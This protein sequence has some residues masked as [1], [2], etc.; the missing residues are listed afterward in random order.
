M[1]FKL[2]NGVQSFLDGSDF[3][4]NQ[5]NPCAVYA[6]ATIAS[7]ILLYNECWLFVCIVLLVVGVDGWTHT[8]TQHTPIDLK[9][10]DIFV[11]FDCFY[12]SISLCLSLACVAAAVG[13]P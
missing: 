4:P 2:C 9:F 11:K 6:Y 7:A 8:H 3:C 10:I 12:L 1:R 13:K 5:N